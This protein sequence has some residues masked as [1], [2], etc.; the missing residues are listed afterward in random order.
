MKSPKRI[1]VHED[2]TIRIVKLK[3]SNGNTNL[4]GREGVVTLINGEGQLRGTWGS[5]SIIE[6]VDEIEIIKK[7]N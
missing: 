4:N 6:G 3:S 7:G 1:S 2:D 5:V